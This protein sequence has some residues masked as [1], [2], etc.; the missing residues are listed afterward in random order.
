[1]TSPAPRFAT[2]CHI[3]DLGVTGYGDLH[4]MIAVSSP[5][6][7]WAPSSAL[8]RDPAC[9]VTPSQFV[10]YVEDGHIRIVAR[11]R[12]IIDR[13]ARDTHPWDGARWDPEVDGALRALMEEDLSVPE[14]RARRVVVAED[15]RGWDLAREAVETDREGTEAWERLLASDEAESSIPPGTLERAR[16]SGAGD[17]RRQVVAV[18]R[19]AYNHGDALTESDADI[20]FLMRRTDREFISRIATMPCA[21]GPG[22]APVTD[23]SAAVSPDLAEVTGQLLDALR[24]IERD[25]TDIGKFVGSP[26]HAALVSWVAALCERIK[27]EGVDAANTDMA[28]ELFSQVEQGGFPGLSLSTVRR[29][30][31]SLEALGAALG[32]VDLWYALSPL[33]SGSAGA[34]DLLSLLA[35]TFPVG[36]GLCKRMGWVPGLFDGPEWPFLYAGTEATRRSKRALLKRLEEGSA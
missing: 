35:A 2:F 21:A 6:N 7:L 13:E 26:Q 36:H 12:W 16:R 23:T 5:L 34:K 28:R 24:R 31:T 32:G 19:D 17:P 1:M 4:R 20:S 25:R 18:L 27:R 29:H 10:K 14:R 15:E 22:A 33:V 3:S 11:R 8:L 30:A 9:R